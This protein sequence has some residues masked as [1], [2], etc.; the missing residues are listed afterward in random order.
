MS[1]DT[2]TAIN[3]ADFEKYS[4]PIPGRE[5]I[6][7]LF[8]EPGKFLNREQLGKTLKL[9]DDEE[10]EALRRR[11]R[12]M[13]RD[14]Q[15]NFDPRKGYS[16][17]TSQDMVEG[18]IIGHPDG[19]GFLSI[20]QGGD[21]LFLHDS[22]MLKAF[23][24]DRVQA[25]ITGTDRRG[26]QEAQIVNVLEKNMTELVGR[27]R[28]EDGEYY[29]QPENSR[30]CNEIDIP[31]DQ[32]KGAQAGQYVTVEITE[33]PCNRFNAEGRVVEI[34]GDSMAPG[35][36]IDVAIR[37]H[38]IPHKWPKDALAAAEALGEE[39]KE[40]DK[41]HRA[42]LRALP[43]VTIDG[44][45]ARDFDDAV[46]CEKRKSGGW[47]LFVAIADV[48]HYVAPGSALDQEAAERGTSVYFPGHV[49]PMLPEALSNGLCSLNPHVDRLVMVCEMAINS[50]GKMTSYKFSEGIIHSHARLTYTQ[51]GALVSAPETELGRAVARN[52][53]DVVPHI[54]SLHHLYAV[55]RKARTKRG[56]I[57]FE[58][59]EVQFKFTEDR[60]I[61]SIVPV[62]RNDAHKMIEE[63][64]LCANVAT[65]QFLEK[66]E[67]P[68]LYRVHEGPVEKKLTNLRAFLGER[69]LNLAGGEKPTPAHYDRLLKGL[70]E[71]PDA[72][73]IRMMM[74]RSLS[75]AEYSSDNQ[76]HFGLAYPAYAHFTSPIRRYPDLLVHRAIRS[77]IRRSESGSV[78]RRALKKVTGVGSDPVQRIKNATP[79]APGNS[80]PYDL[81]AM[82][83]LAEHC[84]TVSRRADKAGW[85]VEAWLKCEYM[86]DHVGDVFSGVISTVTNF[87]LFIELD[88]T[89]VE[90]LVHVTALN[91]DYYQFDAAQQRLV[92]ERT[93]ASFGIGDKI[94]IRVVRVDMDQRKIEFEL[95][96]KDEVQSAPKPRKRKGGRG[97]SVKGAGKAPR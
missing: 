60:K 55:L 64:M 63:F 93:H 77:V 74:L 7:G 43:F 22:Q 46:Y 42:D 40:T 97:K 33:Y 79:L 90:G 3:A 45:D 19:F 4:N 34:L 37:N 68:A 47:R 5:Y 57:D 32:L 13:E 88:D 84:S 41:Q 61:E 69:G 71:R 89:Q 78:I 6:M 28:V 95:A 30:I 51:V 31:D 83:N 62:V 50:A 52:H 76:G 8:D 48:S 73:I 94:N 18:K 15:L 27:L 86:Q 54:H 58:K 36:E 1:I 10:K 59:Q 17:L 39:V 65:A 92:G 9:F 21:D 20:D 35:M 11:L 70:G 75:Q 72:Q 53:T 14:G 85:D 25:R 56:S 81:A 23:P 29:L 26:R 67:I 80:Y 82:K 2:K 49:V 96:V 16:L 38:D 44:E 24:G 91:N 12:A 87:G 66:L